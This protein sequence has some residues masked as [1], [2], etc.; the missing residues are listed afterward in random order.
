M[1]FMEVQ[2]SKSLTQGLWWLEGI[3]NNFLFHL[4]F[5]NHNP[6][7]SGFIKSENWRSVYPKLDLKRNFFP[8][9]SK[10]LFIYFP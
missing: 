3:Y 6:E 10:P 8:L 4:G 9:S 1:D 2:T 5:E 7:R